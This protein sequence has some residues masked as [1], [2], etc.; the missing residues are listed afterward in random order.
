MGSVLSKRRPAVLGKV[1]RS[2]DGE[3]PP[4]ARFWDVDGVPVAL[5]PTGGDNLTFVAYDPEPRLFLSPSVFR[6][7]TPISASAFRAISARFAA[8]G[9]TIRS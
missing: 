4:L 1:P 3:F 8:S 6:N 5:V 2:A 7:G 9:A